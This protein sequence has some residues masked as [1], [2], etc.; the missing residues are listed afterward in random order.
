M[1]IRQSHEIN[2]GLLRK[3]STKLLYSH[4][5]GYIQLSIFQCIRSPGSPSAEPRQL[6][7]ACSLSY[8]FSIANPKLQ[9]VDFKP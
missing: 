8:S 7:S 3:G 5:A 6:G 1:E 9:N 2:K 4:F